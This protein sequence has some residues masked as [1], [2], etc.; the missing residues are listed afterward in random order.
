MKTR[1]EEDFLKDIIPY[2]CP[3]CGNS[4]KFTTLRELKSH[5]EKEHSFKMGYVK[6]RTR[7]KVFSHRAKSLSSSDEE[8]HIPTRLPLVQEAREDDKRL[9]TL[10]DSY[11]EDARV[12]EEQ[13]RSAKDTE[14]VNKLCPSGRAADGGLRALSVQDRLSVLNTEV[15][16]SRQSQWQTEDELHKAHDI[17][18]GIEKA[19]ESRCTDQREVIQGLVKNLKD[20]EGKL[21]KANGLLDKLKN[22]REKLV[23]ETEVIFQDA[24]S[25]N[26]SLREELMRRESQLSLVS[27]KLD[28]VKSFANSEISNRNHALNQASQKIEV[29]EQDRD[30]LIYETDRLLKQAD[31]NATLLKKTLREKEEQLEKVNVKY[32][33]LK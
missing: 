11:R 25:G 33:K 24:E 9:S 8:H 18:G 21:V 16:N 6:P 15:M 20:K 2:R 32:D 4:K 22:E 5:L 30:K 27:E 19:A 31:S 14:S 10:M 3:K 26:E 7:V 23:Q 29:L 13:L 28:D 1:S 12:L 17:L